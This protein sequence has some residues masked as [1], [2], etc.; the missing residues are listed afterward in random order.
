M[1]QIKPQTIFIMKTTYY[2]FIILEN[3]NFTYWIIYSL[4]PMVTP[5]KHETNIYIINI[6][7]CLIYKIPAC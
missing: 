3:I 1:K 4:H 2:Y 7:K 5:L 6:Y